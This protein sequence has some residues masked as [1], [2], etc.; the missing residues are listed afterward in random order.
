[1]KPT[2]MSRPVPAKAD[3]RYYA[4]FKPYGMLCQFTR[5]TPEQVTLADLDFTFSTDVYPVGRLDTDSEGLL[6]LTNDKTLNAR[7]LN[8]RFAHPRTYWAQVEGSP[9]EADLE[10]LRSGVEIRIDGKTHQTLPA[11]AQVLAEAPTVPER[12]PPVRFRKTVPDAWLELTL[13]EG[14]NRQVR[15]MCA[16]VGLPVL[17]L[18]RVAIGGLQLGD[19]Y[20]GAVR[21]LSAEVIQRQLF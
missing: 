9:A 21:E 11:K 16:A 1:M 5:E 6:V 3:L 17:R 20:P 18:V 4:I 12:Y 13:T 10:R 14:K 7:M 15:R 2:G 8:P 19:M